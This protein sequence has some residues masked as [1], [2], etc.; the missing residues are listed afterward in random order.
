MVST[1]EVHAGRLAR[2]FQRNSGP[3]CSIEFYTLQ[4][5]PTQW[6][7]VGRLTVVEGRRPLLVGIGTTEDAAILDLQGRCPH[8]ESAMHVQ[9]RRE[10][11]GR[12]L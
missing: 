2:L 6:V 4:P 3:T 8:G 11:E 1:A 7:A 10:Q 5:A 12:L 9:M